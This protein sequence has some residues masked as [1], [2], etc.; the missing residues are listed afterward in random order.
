MV[1]WHNDLLYNY[2]TN[3]LRIIENEILGPIKQ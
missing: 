1:R 2:A 3:K